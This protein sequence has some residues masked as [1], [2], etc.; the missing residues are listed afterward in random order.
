[1]KERRNKNGIVPSSGNVFADLGLRNPAV[2]Q[3]KVRL[4]VKINRILSA[5]YLSQSAAAQLLHTTQPEMSALQS[6]E[7]DAFSVERL[8]NFW[9]VLALSED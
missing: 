2:K 7:L 6:Y 9:M 1:M 4:A 8:R 3:T 5:R